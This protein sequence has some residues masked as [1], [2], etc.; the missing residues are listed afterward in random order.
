MRIASL[1]AIQRGVIAERTQDSP[2]RLSHAWL[3]RRDERIA[4]KWGTVGTPCVPSWAI[5][6]TRQRAEA[7]R[8]R[9]NR[10]YVF[11]TDTRTSP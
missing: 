4:A 3:T 5:G 11:S 1:L 10:A 6:S 2:V 7:R 9:I 8:R